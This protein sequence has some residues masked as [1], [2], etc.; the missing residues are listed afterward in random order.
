M[1]IPYDAVE[2][3]IRYMPKSSIR[4]LLNAMGLKGVS[5]SVLSAGEALMLWFAD[6]MQGSAKVAS[7]YQD[8]ILSEMSENIE[9]YGNTLET[10][11]ASNGGDLA[12]LPVGLVTVCNGSM[13]CISGR[14]AVLHLHQAAWLPGMPSFPEE[15][16]VYNLAAIYIGAMRGKKPRA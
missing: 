5:P 3:K 15:S 7:S 13:A 1:P 8:L 9:A 2:E 16:I 14:D 4:I 11:L 10:A 6:R 12:K